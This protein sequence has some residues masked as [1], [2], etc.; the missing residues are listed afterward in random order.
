V[1]CKRK[2][3]FAAAPVE[4]LLFLGVIS[5]P[6]P[7]SYGARRLSLLGPPVALCAALLVA[8]CS[9]VVNRVAFLPNQT[10][11]VSDDL[12]PAGVRRVFVPTEDGE[13]LEALL[14]APELPATKLVLYFHGNAGNISQRVHQLEALA[15][16]TNAA[17]FGL[18]YR[19][20]G[21]SSGQPSE[22]GIYR[23]GEAAL[24]YVKR[25]LGFADHQIVVC[26]VSLGSAVAVNTA[27]HRELAGVI[28][29]TPMTSGR[30]LA[31]EHNRGSMAWIAGGA[32]D[33]LSKVAR[34][35]S[36]VLVIHGTLDEVIPYRMGRQ[37]FAAI[38]TPKRFVTIEGARHGNVAF[39]EPRTFWSAIST[40]V[41]APPDT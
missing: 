29:I 16:A 35:R 17:V 36:P 33:S 30:E 40:F 21:A 10:Y 24:R 15:R 12:L 39:V 7:T 4:C 2:N 26:G 1:R 6:P 37:L 32:F 8:G 5:H 27:M 25:E 34:L 19:G 22:R 20:Y 11:T 31:R 38:P 28:L 18:G 23:D 13:R 14:A 3:R 9:S 41:A